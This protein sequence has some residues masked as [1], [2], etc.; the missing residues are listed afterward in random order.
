MHFNIG[1]ATSA[2]QDLGIFALVSP[3]LESRIYAF[4]HWSRRCWVAGSLHSCIGLSTSTEQDLW[5]SMPFCIGL[6]TS[7]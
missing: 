6:T 1:L 2:E 4:L 5:H 7:G 3:F